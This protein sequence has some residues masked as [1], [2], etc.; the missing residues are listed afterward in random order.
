MASQIYFRFQFWCVSH[1]RTSKSIRIPNFAKIAQSMARILLSPVSENKRPP[2]WNS[3]SGFTLTF[4][5]SSACDSRSA[6]QILSK[7]DHR[8]PSYNVITTFKMAATAYFRFLLW[9]CTAILRTSKSIYILNFD[10]VAQSA[11]EILLFPVFVNKRPPYWNFTSGVHVTFPTLSACDSA[12]ACQIPQELDNQRQSYDVLAIFKMAE[13]ASQI[14]FR[15]SFW[16]RIAIKKVKIY[17]RTKFRQPSSIPGRGITI[18]GFWKQTA[19]ILKFYFQ[20]LHRAYQISCKSDHPRP[21]YDVLAIFKMTG[22]A[23]EIYFRFPLW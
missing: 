22:S 3:T 19:T 7:S 5:S 23:S 11:A 4:P 2:Y 17:L 1:V 15:F 12:S 14:Y 8:R 21:I 9:W 20:F 16:W 6:Y 18:S 13:T 10:N